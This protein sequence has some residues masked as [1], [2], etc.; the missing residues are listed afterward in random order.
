[1]SIRIERLSEK[2]FSDYEKLTS[3]GV[4]GGCYCAFWHGKWKS[5]DE[6]KER[7][8]TR[9]LENRDL[10]RQKMNLGFHVGVLVYQNDKLAAWISVGPLPEY[11]WNWKRVA[12]VGENANQVAAIT[13]LTIAPELRSQKL[14]VPILQALSEYGKAQGWK[15]IEG[16]PF[17]S[18]A[19]EKHGKSVAWPGKA[20]G[21]I[22]AGYSRTGA[23][24]LN[25]PDF[26]RSIYQIELS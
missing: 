6:W 7:E 13:C 16:Y 25:H 11:Y 8:K 15:A 2:N 4:D 17:E 26:E 24:W 3:C 14:Q 5:V 12:Q 9:P 1:M 23:H 22:S 10:I 19:Y 21:Y 20:A 18:S